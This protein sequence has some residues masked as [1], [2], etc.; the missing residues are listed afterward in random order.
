MDNE[1]CELPN[2]YV[3]NE[4]EEFMNPRQ[5]EYFRRIL[6]KWKEDI[7]TSS[8]AIFR[9]LQEDTNPG[10][11]FGDRAY[12]ETDLTCELRARNREAKLIS[13]ID[14]ALAK[15]ANGTYGYCEE[16]GLPIGV[17]RLLARPVATLCIEA[18]K[19]HEKEEKLR[20]D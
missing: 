17:K 8:D 9:Y 4:E 13:K 6:L 7:I 18:Q 20:N 10:T 19:R 3:P 12:I 16:T 5:L 2:G 14:E 1:I 15:I 11:D